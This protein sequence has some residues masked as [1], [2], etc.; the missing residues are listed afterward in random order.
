M[1]ASTSTAPTAKAAVE[2]V[3]INIIIS[4]YHSLGLNISRQTVKIM[5][6]TQER[7]P[8]QVWC[9]IRHLNIVTEKYC[10]RRVTPIT[11]S[12]TLVTLFY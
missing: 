3:I 8:Q 9:Y 4:Q 11:L 1:R 6:R 12:L 10:S 2:K 7:L 5:L